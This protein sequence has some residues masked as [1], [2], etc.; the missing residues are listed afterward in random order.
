MSQPIIEV[1]DLY[2]SFKTG[3]RQELLVLENLNFKMYEGE[4]V[5]IVGQSG[6]GKSTL[7]RLIAG[8]LSPSKG[9]VNYRNQ[10]VTGPVRGMSMV[11][12]TFALLPWLTVLQNVELGLEALGVLPKVR[13]E[14]SLKVIDMIGLDG[15]ESALPKELS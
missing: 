9:T 2:K 8:L 4:I 6:S 11:F 7:L 10:S 1:I 12:Q 5:A 14:R 3:D 13:R 15:F